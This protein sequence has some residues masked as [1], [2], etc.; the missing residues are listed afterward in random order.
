MLA[1]AFV[2]DR[3]GVP[4][5]HLYEVGEGEVYQ[6]TDF[7]T[8]VQGITALSP[9]LSWAHSA[10]KLAFVYFE[11]GK[12]DVY[13]LTNPRNLKKQPWRPDASVAQKSLAVISPTGAAAQPAVAAIKPPAGPQILGGG[14]I[15]RTTH[16]FRR[17]DSL[18]A[19]PDSARPAGGA[20]PGALAQN[21]DSLSF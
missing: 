18:P 10:D 1:V 15:Y 11:Q 19:V 3:T 6:L 4:K 16:G 14:A 9:V 17:A 8:G 20:A 7:Y 21:P 5:I 12:Y 2:S 13:T